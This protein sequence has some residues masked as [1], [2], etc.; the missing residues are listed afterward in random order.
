MFGPKREIVVGGWRKLHH[1]QLHNLHCSPNVIRVIKS[2]RMK[3]AGHV[4]HM[5]GDN[6][7]KFLPE[8][9]TA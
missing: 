3:W 2:K 9:K 7:Y 5:S 6:A 4:A 1:E 8:D